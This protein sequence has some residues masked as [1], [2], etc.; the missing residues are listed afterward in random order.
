MDFPDTSI[1]IAS[2]LNRYSFQLDLTDSADVRTHN[3]KAALPD[4]TGVCADRD[5]WHTKKAVLNHFL[6]FETIE[7]LFSHLEK[8]SLQ[9]FLDIFGC[10]R[11]KTVASASSAMKEQFHPTLRIFWSRALS[12]THFAE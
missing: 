11:T 5:V 1:T 3:S 7:V 2:L 9:C 12:A 8:Y 10:E 4:M 6:D